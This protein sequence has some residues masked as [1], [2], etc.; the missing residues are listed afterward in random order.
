MALTGGAG[1]LEPLSLSGAAA[2]QQ[3]SHTSGRSAATGFRRSRLDQD[4]LNL[5]EKKTC[6]LSAKGA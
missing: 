2:L 3:Q 4:G 1:L 6:N 5:I